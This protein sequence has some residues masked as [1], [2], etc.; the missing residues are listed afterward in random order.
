M[1]K[2]IIVSGANFTTNKLD[3]VSFIDRIPCEG[4]SLNKSTHELN[5][6]G[7]TVELVATLAPVDTTDTL[8]WE[9]SDSAVAEV[10]NGIV[11]AVKLGTATITAR[12]GE[13]TATCVITV[14]NVVPDYVAVSGYQPFLRSV[15]GT[16][17]T[18]DKYTGSGST[19][20]KFIIACDKSTGLYPIETKDVDTSPY[21]FVPILIPAGAT[22]VKVSTTLGNFKTRTLW[23][24]S[25]KPETTYNIGA[26][27]VQ[28]S[29]DT[30]DQG[31][32]APSPITLDIP[33]GVIG[34][35]SVCIAI[36]FGG[37]VT[38]DEMFADFSDN[39]T[40]EFLIGETT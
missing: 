15:G 26:Y 12:C 5:S 17:C 32:T 20:N 21:R 4:I 3:T 28:G 22:Q 6:I 27:C 14:D 35:D 38:V 33:T 10:N 11:V 18:T 39:I 25:T 29:T 8:S 37:G 23:F 24:D 1:A 2:T 19:T 40:I 31:S 36:I 13:Q 16:A 9:S 7:G 34:L 30:Y